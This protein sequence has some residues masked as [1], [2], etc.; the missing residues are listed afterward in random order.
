VAVLLP[1][2]LELGVDEKS[3]V[4]LARGR[5]HR[6]DR[7]ARDRIGLRVRRGGTAQPG[8]DISMYRPLK[9]L[10]GMRQWLSLRDAGVGATVQA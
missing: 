7:L 9:S 8:R 4:G 5:V 1:A 10:L 2:C 6:A 3:A